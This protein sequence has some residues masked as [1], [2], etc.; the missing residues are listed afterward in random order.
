MRELDRSPSNSRVVKAST[1]YGE[2][3]GSEDT[4]PTGDLAPYPCVQ[5]LVEPGS[6][7]LGHT[8]QRIRELGRRGRRGDP[9]E[10]ELVGYQSARDRLLVGDHQIWLECV[11]IAFRMPAAIASASGIRI[12]SP[13]ETVARPVP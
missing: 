4:A 3:R 10:P 2:N 5:E 9:G 11:L 1:P 8:G 12:S 13:T 6:A 7:T